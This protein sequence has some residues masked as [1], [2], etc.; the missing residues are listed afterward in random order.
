MITKYDGK[1]PQKCHFWFNQVHV[2][3]LESGRNFQQALMFCAEDTILSVLS[4]QG[5]LM[6]R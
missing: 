2:A 4:V 6:K 5:F 1:D 3:C